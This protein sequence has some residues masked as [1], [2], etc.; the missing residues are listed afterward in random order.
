MN[1]NDPK[2]FPETYH[3]R[4]AELFWSKAVVT[5]AGCHVW[6]DKPTRYGTFNIGGVSLLAHRIAYWLTKGPIAP[7]LLVRHRCDVP[8]C[9]NPDHLELGTHA[10]N[11]R[12]LK[13]RGPSQAMR[14]YGP[15]QRHHGWNYLL[16]AR[17]RMGIPFDVACRIAGCSP[18]TL[19]Q[20]ENGSKHPDV[21]KLQKM[22]WAYG[23]PYG[24]LVSGPR[25]A[26]S[27]AP[28]SAA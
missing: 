27:E 26:D 15:L 17:E 7:G 1:R 6:N 24:E 16:S 21:R 11:S 12:D 22:A 9:I 10:D 23:V 19:E 5:Q 20:F 4:E 14:V 3:P 13:K 8:G 28:P 18:S 2:A 25:A